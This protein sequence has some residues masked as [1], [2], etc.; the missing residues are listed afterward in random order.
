IPTTPAGFLRRMSIAALAAGCA[1]TLAACG[2]D[3]GAAADGVF[4]VTM[5][6]FHYGDLPDEVPAGTRL[7]IEN[8]SAT[9]LHEL[10]AFRLADDDDRTVEEILDGDLAGL[11]STAPPA[12]V[13]LAAPGGEQI[14]A[15]G[16]GTLTE[17]GRYLLLCAI[18]TGADP[19]EYLAAAATSDGPPQVD[20]GPPHFVHGMADELV[21]TG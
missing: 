17:P 12:T 2:D 4:E 13:L 19:D 11:L 21:V 7:E 5:A 10:V 1:V 6:D 18:P 14:A 20:G 16:D 8:T 9:E 3:A 15:V